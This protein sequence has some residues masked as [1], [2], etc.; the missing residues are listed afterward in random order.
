V[1]SLFPS[2]KA[3]NTWFGGFDTH[4][5]HASYTGMHSGSE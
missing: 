3:T 1:K 4:T 5:D 2:S